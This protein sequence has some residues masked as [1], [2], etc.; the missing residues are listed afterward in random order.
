MQLQVHT[1][2]VGECFSTGFDFTDHINI[3]PTTPPVARYASAQCTT[4]LMFTYLFLQFH[5]VFSS[6]VEALVC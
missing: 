3:Q 5:G 4:W 2:T 6:M 1:E